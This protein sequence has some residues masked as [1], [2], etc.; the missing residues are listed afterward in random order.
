M[1]GHHTPGPWRADIGRFAELN[2]VFQAGTGHVVA[3]VKDGGGDGLMELAN[4]HLIAAAPEMLAA[5]QM[6]DRAISGLMGGNTVDAYEGVRIKLS[7][8]NVE[9]IRAALA[10]ALGHPAPVQR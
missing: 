5:L 4:T 7:V 6:I 8:P 1:A 2:H 10:K 9:A 3:V